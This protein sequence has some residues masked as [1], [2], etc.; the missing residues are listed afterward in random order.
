MFENGVVNCI[1]LGLIPP[2]LPC[3]KLSSVAGVSRIPLPRQDSHETRSWP[4]GIDAVCTA[5]LNKEALH[6]RGAIF[7][8]GHTENARGADR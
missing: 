2:D 7:Y 5:P 8:P 4:V 3:G 6:G 1:D